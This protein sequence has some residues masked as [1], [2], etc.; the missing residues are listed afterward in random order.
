MP[1]APSY[2][3][4][5]LV[6]LVAELEDRL[7][8]ASVSPTLDA[9]LAAGIPDAETFVLV[10]FDGL[11]MAQLGH[12]SASALA[13]SNQGVLDAPFPT[14]TSVALATLATGLSASQ[15]GVVAHLSWMEDI[16]QVVNT[17]KWVNLSGEHIPYDYP[18]VLPR[19]NLWERLR[20]AGVEPITVQPWNFEGSPLSRVL[21]RGTRFE[22][23]FDTNDLIDATVQLAG[24]SGRFIFTYV[25]QVDFAGHVHGLDSE[26]FSD[27]VALANEVW[28]GLVSR[29]PPDVTLIGT[30]DHGL[31]EFPE[32]SKIIS[33]E[34]RYAALRFAGDTRGVQLWGDHNLMD[35]FA[36]ATGG[37]LVNPADLVGPGLTEAARSRL[38]QRVLLAPEG[39]VILPPGFDKRLRCYH[40]GLAPAEVEIPLLVG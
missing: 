33:R 2:D 27:A 6:N 17:L 31:I 36:E 29:L 15:H 8:G 22:R 11:G 7:T 37:E 25:W 24:S 28:E 34:D 19:P 30:A 23:A 40:G 32:S 13:A 9:S 18:S 21:Y 20:N 4:H 5:G 16:G 26:D 35:E 3:S 1:T 10:L 39:K 12:P 38:G 14:T